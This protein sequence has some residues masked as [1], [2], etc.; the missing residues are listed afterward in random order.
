M[1]GRDGRHPRLDLGLLDLLGEAALAAHQVMVMVVAR[2]TAIQDLAL[3]GAQRV[4]APV[5]GEPLQRAVHGR[6]ADALPLGMQ[7][8][9]NLLGATEVADARQLVQ[10]GLALLGHAL[11]GW[12]FRGACQRAAERSGCWLYVRATR[13]LRTRRMRSRAAL[14]I[15][16]IA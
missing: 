7:V 14:M 2:A 4:H 9:E 16:P 8:L 13:S 12:S 6:Q 5:L 15:N 1:V 11:H 3:G 10:D